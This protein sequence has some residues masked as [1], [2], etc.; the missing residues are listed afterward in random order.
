MAGSPT[1]KM[2]RSQLSPSST[3]TVELPAAI[4]PPAVTRAKTKLPPPP[5][6]PVT[7][8][9]Y[10][11]TN[12][13]RQSQAHSTITEKAAIA[14]APAAPAA[15]VSEA[16]PEVT[17]VGSNFKLD[18]GGRSFTLSRKDAK[19]LADKLMRALR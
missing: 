17:A 4:K 15:Q 10:S 6:R 16:V 2:T 11:V 12:K 13:S 18:L 8:G 3:P 1:R 9:A 19:T 14:A 7:G 5:A